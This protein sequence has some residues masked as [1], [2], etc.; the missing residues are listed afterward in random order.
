[1][2]FVCARA[3]RAYG[4]KNGLYPIAKGIL[5]VGLT[6]HNL[7]HVSAFVSIAAIMV[8]TSAAP[9]RTLLVSVSDLPMFPNAGQTATI[10]LP[11]VDPGFEWNEAIASWNVG[12]PG[13]ST[14]KIEACGI[15]GP[16]KTKWYCLGEWRAADSASPRH[17]VAHQADADGEVQTDTLRLSRRVARC[18][19]RVTLT[20]GSAP[21]PTFKLLTVCF[22]DDKIPPAE[23]APIKKAWGRTID[24]PE[25]SQMPYELG[26]MKLDPATTPPSFR[27]WYA[28]VKTSQFCSPTSLSMTLDYWGK[29]LSRPDLNQDLPQVAIGVFDAVYAGTGNWPFN[30]AYAGSW[31]GIRAYVSRFD[32][33]S[34]LES[35]IAAGVPVICSVSYHRLLGKPSAGSDGHLVVLVGFSDTGDPVFND[36]GHSDGVRRTYRRSDFEEAWNDSSRTVYLVYPETLTAP[37]NFLGHWIGHIPG[38]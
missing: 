19:L 31:P 35:W 36:P 27:S 5:V 30:T 24:V 6:R 15:D 25:R 26:K 11:V 2:W 17:S 29:K 37:D 23:V 13:D 18:G 14:L 22:S 33:V 12:N 3:G 32:S 4:C 38:R 28:G 1:M 20:T 8:M 16:K 10:E 7:D 34:E 9:R 21:I